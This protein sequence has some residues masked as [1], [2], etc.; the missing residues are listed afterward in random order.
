MRE[1]R[2]EFQDEK[3]TVMSDVMKF[4]SSNDPPSFSNY[5]SDNHFPRQLLR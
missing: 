5:L 2:E 3:V 1:Q 4:V